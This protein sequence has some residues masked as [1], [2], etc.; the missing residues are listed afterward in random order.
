VGFSN[1]DFVTNYIGNF[2]TWKRDTVLQL[3]EY[4][5]QLTDKSWI[6]SIPNCWYFSEYTFYGVFV[7]QV[8]KENSGHYFDSQKV[9]HDYWGTKALSKD[10]LENLFQNIPPEYFAVMI[11]A[12]S[13]MSVDNYASFIK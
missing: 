10:E 8:L 7:E 6:E 2:I 9:S 13:K 5:E 4:V 11:S 12:K 1:Q 3:H